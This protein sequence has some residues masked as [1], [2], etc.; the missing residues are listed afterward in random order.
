MRFPKPKKWV[1]LT[2]IGAKLLF[3]RILFRPCPRSLFHADRA[4]LLAYRSSCSSTGAVR[5]GKDRRKR[6]QN[7]PFSAKQ[8]RDFSVEDPSFGRLAVSS[9]TFTSPTE[10]IPSP[11]QPESP[12]T[13]PRQEPPTRKKIMGRS[14][15]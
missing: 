1:Q 12:K 2:Q 15:S 5:I 14:L 10:P 6:A 4:Q 13:Q 8:V 7:Q 9:G 11:N 3:L